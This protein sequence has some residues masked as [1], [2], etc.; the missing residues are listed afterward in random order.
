MSIIISQSGKDAKKIDQ[1]DFEKEDYLQNY[2]HKNPESIPV[3][4]I[5]QDKRL[6]VITREFPTESGPIDALAVDQD[7]DIYV[8]EGKLSL[9]VKK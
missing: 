8:V 7:G 6:F 1:S 4:E 3:Y 9:L 5:A 2:I